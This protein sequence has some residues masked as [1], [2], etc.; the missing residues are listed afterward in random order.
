MTLELALYV[1]S[2]LTAKL[3][4]RFMADIRFQRKKMF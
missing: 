1:L 4:I 2:P 3:G